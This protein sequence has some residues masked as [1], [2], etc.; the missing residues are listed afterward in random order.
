V[1]LIVIDSV[2]CAFVSRHM[3]IMLKPWTKVQSVPL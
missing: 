2:A 1:V 3:L